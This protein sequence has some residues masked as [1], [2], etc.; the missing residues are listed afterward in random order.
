MRRIIINIGEGV[1][2]NEAMEAVKSVVADGRISGSDGKK[3]YC[4]VTTFTN[5]GTVVAGLT[6]S[7]NDTFMVYMEGK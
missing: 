4:Y 2:D 6:R 5:G 7:G 3:Q 1:D